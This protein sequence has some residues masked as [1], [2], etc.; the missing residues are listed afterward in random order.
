MLKDAP[1]GWAGLL[2]AVISPLVGQTSSLVTNRDG[3][4]LYFAAP[5]VQ[6]GTDQTNEPKIFRWS[7]EGLRL[8]DQV[9]LPPVS[10]FYSASAP[11]VDVSEDEST[12]AIMKVAGGCRVDSCTNRCVDPKCNRLSPIAPV[13][14]EYRSSAG[15]RIGFGTG[16]V[17]RN[18]RFGL[19][20][21]NL[22]LDLAN[23]IL[24]DLSTGASMSLDGNARSQ[25]FAQK[26]AVTDD[27]RVVRI[28]LGA[29]LVIK[30]AISSAF[31]LIPT[32]T[33]PLVAIINP[34]G[35][36]IIFQ[37]IENDR[38]VLYAHDLPTA[39][40]VRLH[41]GPSSGVDWFGP[42]LQHDGKRVLA[43]DRDSL[44]LPRQ[45]LLLADTDGSA[46]RRFA[47]REEGYRE[48]TISGNGKVIFAV[49]WWNAIVRID[50]ETGEVREI[51]PPSPFIANRT[52]ALRP[53]AENRITGARF[54]ESTLTPPTFPAF[55][56]GGYQVLLGG[57]PLPVLSVSPTELVYQ[58]PW[59]MPVPA[60]PQALEVKLPGNDASPFEG[61][62]V[63]VTFP[64]DPQIEP[65]LVREDGTPV[66]AQAKLRP[67]E[68]VDAYVTGWLVGGVE[69][70]VPASGWPDPLPDPVACEFSRQ[71]FSNFAPPTWDQA[72]V[73]WF[74]QAPLRAG[75]L[76]IRLRVPATI[77]GPI[78][79]ANTPGPILRCTHPSGRVEMPVP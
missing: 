31:A 57:R 59:E 3:E 26:Q 2:V 66:T 23:P 7:D 62:G 40:N 45:W 77:P 67:G 50:A 79:N 48:A 8:I 5:L 22:G 74:R 63:D 14:T 38:L 16:S 20:P 69:S 70:G 78:F 76:Q 49:T 42:V 10:P 27:G 1:L 17:S 68:V 47:F 61:P 4:W 53:G 60:R 37:S 65:Q 43:L 13:T 12:T 28:G 18:G 24:Y 41:S 21:V 58:I 56:I 30:N 9:P 71:V 35:D 19:A 75:A 33:V 55:D 52:G 46:L 32:P 51:I 11:A 29:G 34:P 6:R 15:V 25:R 73:L 44:D 64:G 54:A 36:R 39:R 72:D